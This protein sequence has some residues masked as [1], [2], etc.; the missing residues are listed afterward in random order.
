[1]RR[2][3]TAVSN[4]S[5][6]L[7]AIVEQL[8]DKAKP[9][10]PFE[11]PYLYPLQRIPEMKIPSLPNPLNMSPRECSHER[12]SNSEPKS[13]DRGNSE[14]RPFHL[15]SRV[16]RCEFLCFQV[17]LLRNALADRVICTWMAS[18]SIRAGI[19]FTGR[20]GFSNFGSPSLLFEQMSHM[21]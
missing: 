14:V 1:M 12:V 3:E 2:S 18:A 20:S 13:H 21:N 9:V 16:E 17:L 6:G 8:T 7:I 11:Q 19:R 10:H 4:R 5:F 15:D